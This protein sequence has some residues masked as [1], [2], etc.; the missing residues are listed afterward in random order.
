MM[1]QTG[2]IMGTQ[3]CLR[4]FDPMSDTTYPDATLA[5]LR[6]INHSLRQRVVDLLLSIAILKE[7]QGLP[8]SA[9][10][11]EI[12]QGIPER[13][14]ARSNRSALKSASRTRGNVRGHR[15]IKQSGHRL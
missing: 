2:L 13:S 10:S 5:S 1:T 3:S 8:S 6:E 15:S 11:R 7:A 4:M 14:S 12:G 9:I